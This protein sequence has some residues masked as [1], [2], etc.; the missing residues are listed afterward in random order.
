M[1]PVLGSLAIDPVSALPED[2]GCALSGDAGYAT[3][4]GDADA[5]EIDAVDAGGSRVVPG[6]SSD[7]VHVAITLDARASDQ[8]S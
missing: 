2:A 8:V 5:G 3:L 7:A 6:L 1:D 4:A